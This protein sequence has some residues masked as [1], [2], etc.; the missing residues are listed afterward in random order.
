MQAH[1]EAADGHPGAEPLADPRG[2][3]EEAPEAGAVRVHELGRLHLDV[4][5]GADEEQQRHQEGRGAGPSPRTFWSSSSTNEQE[6]VTRE[7]R[8][9]DRDDTLARMVTRVEGRASRR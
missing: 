8:A 3:P 5:A 1:D 7:A 4:R 2:F 6:G 9:E